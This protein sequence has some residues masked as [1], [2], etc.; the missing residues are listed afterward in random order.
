MSYVVGCV[1]AHLPLCDTY[2]LEKMKELPDYSFSVWEWGWVSSGL[3][4][5]WCGG[6]VWGG[7]PVIYPGEI[8]GKCVLE[9]IPEKKK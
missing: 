7:Q 1:G 8:K 4:V 9:S 6:G 3:L 5:V 2:P